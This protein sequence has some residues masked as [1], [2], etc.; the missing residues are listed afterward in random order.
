M[1][2]LPDLNAALARIGALVG[3]EGATPP[4]TDNALVTTAWHDTLARWVALCKRLPA[5]SPYRFDREALSEMTDAV[6][7]ML[8]WLGAAY[9]NSPTFT[10]TGGWG[11]GG[12][13]RHYRFALS[14]CALRVIF[15][16]RI[17]L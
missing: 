2:S 3:N 16:Q 8:T 11:F 17:G 15:E 6:P 14:L 9:A 10:T 12:D 5:D 4:L 1:S 7:D 13:E